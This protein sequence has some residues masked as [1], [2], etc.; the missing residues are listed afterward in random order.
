VDDSVPDGATPIDPDE[1]ED[2][3]LAHVTTRAELDELEEAN[4]Q[5]G[6]EWARRR[7]LRTS[8]PLDVLTERFLYELHRQMFGSVWEWAGTVRKTDKNIGIDKFAVRT[9]VKKLVEDARYWREHSVFGPVE[10]AVRFH[11][12]LVSIHPFPNGNGRHA[13]MMA[14]LLLEQMGNKPLS[15]GGESL[16]EKS[17]LRSAYIGALQHADNGD[18]RPLLEFAQS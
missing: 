6:L 2:L 17:A 3:L 8:R 9:E 11:H 13:R 15:W 5:Q 16:T 7:A 4:I 10:M 1:A 12:R 18:L 14:D